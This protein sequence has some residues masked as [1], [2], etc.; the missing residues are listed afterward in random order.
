VVTVS[1]SGNTCF[2]SFSK[3]VFPR[4]TYGHLCS[5]AHPRNPGVLG[6]GSGKHWHYQA[7]HHT[8]RN[9]RIKFDYLGMV[10][11]LRD[12]PTWYGSCFA[13]AV[14]LRG[15]PPAAACSTCTRHLRLCWPQAFEHPP[16]QVLN[17]PGGS[18][19]KAWLPSSKS[20]II[21]AFKSPLRSPTTRRITYPTMLLAFP[22][23]TPVI[24]CLRTNCNASRKL[25]HLTSVQVGHKIRVNGN[26]QPPVSGLCDLQTFLLSD[27][28]IQYTFAHMD[29]PVSLLPG[30]VQ[31]C[32]CTLGGDIAWSLALLFLDGPLSVGLLLDRHVV[33]SPAQSPG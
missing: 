32:P 12:S 3:W 9:E 20:P 27:Y 21:N 24:F 4:L 10:G 13:V 5:T 2:G 19:S 29:V 18:R 25:A 17:L 33:H 14:I 6:R 15:N 1:R 7:A 30:F 28:T 31:I 22:Q 8:T 23:V 26:Q 16:I 11:A